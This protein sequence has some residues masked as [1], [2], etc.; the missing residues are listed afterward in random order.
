MYINYK[1]YFLLYFYEF[2]VNILNIC[3]YNLELIIM[4][5]NLLGDLIC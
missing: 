3:F 4:N 5:F 2:L 1:V